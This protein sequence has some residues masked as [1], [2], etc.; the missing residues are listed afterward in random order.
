MVNF[1]PA[2]EK[3]LAAPGA[4]GSGGGLFTEAFGINNHGEVVGTFA[5]GRDNTGSEKTHGFLYA[6]L[7]SAVESQFFAFWADKSS[8]FK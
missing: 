8:R 7:T 4:Q 5:D 3:A 2:A 6:N 1:T